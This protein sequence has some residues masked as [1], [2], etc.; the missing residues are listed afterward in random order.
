MSVAAHMFE[1]L[2]PVHLGQPDVEQYQIDWL[3]RQPRQTFFARADRFDGITF[4]RQDRRERIAYSCFV[5]DD[6]DGGWHRMLRAG[7]R[8]AFRSNR[9]RRSICCRQ[10]DHESRACGKIVFWADDPMML[11]NH[12]A[13]DR[14]P[15]AGSAVLVREMGQKGTVL[16]L[17]RDSITT[18]GNDDLNRVM[19]HVKA[20]A[21]LQIPHSR[22]LH[23]FGRVIDQIDDY[24]PE[25]FR[26]R[27]YLR[28][29]FGEIG[30]NLYIFQPAFE[31]VDGAQHT[32]IWIRWYE[33]RHRETREP[34]RFVDQR[35]H[36]SDP[37]SD[38]IR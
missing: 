37:T 7:G 22:T 30:A 27:P 12:A 25:H 13:G 17:G 23:G 24:A 1:R 33:S 20:R 28:H 29:A 8:L 38:Q 10:L 32:A 31:D 34:R 35:F 6:E 26:I 4:F 3:L 9:D 18:I 19:R 21:Q 11:R 15:K 14:Q 2:D 5:V 16:G 36:P